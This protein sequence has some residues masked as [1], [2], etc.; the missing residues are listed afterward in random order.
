MTLSKSKAL[1]NALSGLVMLC[2]GAAAPALSHAAITLYSSGTIPGTA[3]D[4]SG[5]TGNLAD[6][7]PH[8]R[9]GGLGSGLAY[10]G[11]ENTFIAVPDRGPAD[12]T[13]DYYDRYYALDIPLTPGTTTPLLK[14]T[15][16][17]KTQSGQQ[18]TGLSSAFDTVNPEASLRFDPE[19]VRV[20]FN[21]KLYISDEYGPYVYEFDGSGARTRVISI[22]GKFS[23][24]NSNADPALE[25][26]G[27]A[28][29]RQANRG[30]EGL[31]ITPDGSKLFGMMQNA[32]IQDHALD[33]SQK[34]IGR[35]NR[36]LEMDLWTGE[37]K[38][39]AY[40]IDDKSY[41]VN[42][43]LAI[44][45]SQF[46]VIERDGK[47]GSEAAFKKVIKV[48][49]T[50][51][52]DVSGIE[53]LPE[54]G[55]LPAGVVPVA[56]SS[57][58][59]LLSSGYGLAGAT[60]PEK[61]EGLAFGPDLPDGRH[62]LLVTTDNDFG[63]DKPSQ[64]WVFAFEDGDL[65]GFQPQQFQYGFVDVSS[66]ICTASTGFVLNRSTQLYSGKLTITNKSSDRIDGPLT[67]VL[68][69]LTPGVTLANAT[70]SCNGIPA[71]VNVAPLGLDPGKS[72]TVPVLLRNPSHK[73]I[74]F[75][76]TTL[77]TTNS[78]S[79]SFAV[80]S[81][82]HLYDGDTLGTGTPEFAAYLAQDR[83]LIAESSEILSSVLADLKW[84][85]F[86][87]VLVPGDLTKD[88]ERVNHEMLAGMLAEL[89][90]SGKRV[91]VVPGNHDINN[92]HSL[93]YLT[94]PPTLVANVSPVEFKKI[95]ADFGYKEALFTDPHSVSYIAEPIPGVWLFALDSCQYS[96]SGITAGAF[97]EA[98]RTW[99]VDRL[100]EAR[101]QGKQVIGMMHHGLLEH[102]A[103]QSVLFP[104]YV[105]EDW[106]NLSRLFSDNGLNM[107]F[108]GHF[109]ANDV[110]FA[111]FTSSWLTDVETGSMVTY[112]CPYRTAFLAGSSLAVQTSH[113]TSIASHPFDFEMYARDYLEE[114]LTGITRYQLS[115]PPYNLTEPTLSYVSSLVVSAMMA[116]YAGD[117]SPDTTT[118][119][120]YTSMMSSPDP[121]TRGLGQWLYFLWTD[122]PPA[123][124]DCELNLGS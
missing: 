102:F 115:H 48:D 107:V 91:F 101:A 112:P 12:G 80:F 119:A 35:Y 77:S 36:I 123:D 110:T 86:D 99:V 97:S 92:P 2:M 67:V 44:N 17:L 88:G 33:S 72:A 124:N 28:S 22:P 50:G 21:R 47:V 46:L 31:A 3:T 40:K 109:H 30:M 95:Y 117:E 41:G 93:S 55:D 1:R 45:A 42:E 59:N 16:L 94:S 96:G 37:T 121:V 85:P 116:H 61:V 62:T 100:G 65:P 63:A 23:I 39:Y 114:G 15:V 27:N 52:T 18:L 64:I 81:D 70:G 76:A 38:E 66:R 49:V 120:I 83:K 98:T 84:K 58:I 57:F 103:G 19:G 56:K 69:D 71:V 111:D 6:G 79:G 105:V 7:T 13:V 11:V 108:T 113:V 43:I 53:S 20:G 25:L 54:K 74:R 34:R 51:A 90:K 118:M 78:L 5:L 73:K 8:N 89:E 106:Q 4:T 14:A 10:T 24:P 29:G 82:P 75:S 9:M 104:E 87:F 32:L 60:F 122:L 68:G 26:S